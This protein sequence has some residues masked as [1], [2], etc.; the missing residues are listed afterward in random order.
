MIEYEKEII[1]ENLKSVAGNRDKC[2]KLLGISERTLYRKL[3][4]YNLE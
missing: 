4:E 2:A 3:K 1:R